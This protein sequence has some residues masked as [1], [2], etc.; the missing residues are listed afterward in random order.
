MNTILHVLRYLGSLGGNLITEEQLR[1]DIQA[2]VTP[3]PAGSEISDALNVIQR[4]GWAISQKDP[5]TGSI[6]WRI[7]QSGDAELLARNLAPSGEPG[8]EAKRA[9]RPQERLGGVKTPARGTRRGP[10][11]GG[12]PR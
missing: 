12:T 6:R 7:T 8:L 4:S 2:T 10:G 1:V 3:A 11:I 5:I 9:K